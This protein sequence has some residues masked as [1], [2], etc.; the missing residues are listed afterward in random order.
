MKKLK[1]LYIALSLATSG[2]ITSCSDFLDRPTE[3]SYSAGTFYQDDNQCIQGV[4]YLYNSPWYDFQRGFI[5]VGEVMSGNF[6]WGSSPY[7]TLTVNSTDADLTNMSYSLWSVIGHANTVYNNLKSTK[8]SEIV[9]KQ[10][11]GKRL[12]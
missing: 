1:Y 11:T 5:K 6:Y 7:L 10:L 4:N 3:D 8:A 12:A 9:K 2:L